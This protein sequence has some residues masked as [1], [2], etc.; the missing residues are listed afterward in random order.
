MWKDYCAL[1]KCRRP[2]LSRLFRYPKYSAPG[3]V[4]TNE[5]NTTGGAL[6]FWMID[7]ETKI[8]DA[9]L[10]MSTGT[11]QSNI[12]TLNYLLFDEN[13]LKS[14]G[15]KIVQSSI[16]ANTAVTELKE[17]H[18][19]VIEVDY[20][21]LGVL[22]DMIVDKIRKEKNKTTTKGTIKPLVRKAIEGEKIDYSVLSNDY[23]RHLKTDFKDLSKMIPDAKEKT[24]SCP[25]CST[26]F[27]LP[28]KI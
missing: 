4:I 13:E 5:L 3:D 14:W 28:A 20:H 11:T 23:L 22:Q 26:I 10:A 6:S 12:G 2:L 7:D 18:Y 9:L 15:I 21:T 24:I 27:A 16:D 8:N 1:A 17:K 19:N 25:K